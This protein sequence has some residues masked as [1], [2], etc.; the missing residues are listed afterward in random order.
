L[1]L[2]YPSSWKAEQAQQDGVSYRYFL[3]PPTGPDRKPAVSVTLV[4]G[5]LGVALDQYAQTYLAGNTVQSSRGETRPGARGKYQLFASPDGKTRFA[6]LLL[7]ESAESRTGLPATPAPRPSA[8][9]ASPAPGKASVTVRPSPTPIATPVPAAATAEAPGAYVY[10]LFA[11]GDTAA[12]D[13][14]LPVIEEMV[15]SLT[16]ERPDRYPE[17]KNDKFAFSLRAPASWTSTR[18]FASGTTFLRQYTSPAFGAD[19]AQTVHASLTLTVEPAADVEAYYKATVDKAGDTVGVLSHSPWRGGYVDV[20][21]SE[22]PVAVTRARRY[23]RVADGRGYTLACDARSDIYTRVW[24]WC[25][26]IAAT[27]KIGPEV[28]AP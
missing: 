25:D 8:S 24:R 2:H 1:T 20:I 7:E 9:A 5:P 21:Q 14:Q 10:G 11:Q 12:F 3:A 28:K 15:Q 18:S 23:Y 27:L 26:M 13:A 22:T 16:L 19:K 4:A 6:L 17:E